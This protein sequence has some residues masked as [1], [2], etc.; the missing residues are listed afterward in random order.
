MRNMPRTINPL[1]L[2][3]SQRRWRSGTRRLSFSRSSLLPVRPSHQPSWWCRLLPLLIDE[4]TGVRGL[5]DGINQFLFCAIQRAR[6]CWFKKCVL[7]VF[8]DLLY[9]LY[10]LSQAINR[11]SF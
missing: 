5:H 8:A 4:L 3:A 7:K 11:T 10:F 2:R 9:E 6:I 1:L